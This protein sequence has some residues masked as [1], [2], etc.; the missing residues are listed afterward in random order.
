M[1]SC[2]LQSSLF[3][4]FQSGF[5]GDNVTAVALVKVNRRSSGNGPVSRLVLLSSA[6]TTVDHSVPFQRLEPV[7]GIKESPARVQPCSRLVPVKIE[8]FFSCPCCLLG[9]PG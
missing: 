5:K 8:G 1:S 3:D 6:F 9:A 4:L 2:C 7:P